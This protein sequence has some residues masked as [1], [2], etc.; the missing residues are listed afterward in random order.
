[1]TT[2]S[3]ARRP[4]PGI[5]HERRWWDAGAVVAGVDEVGRGA[6]AG[7]VTVGAVVLPRHRRL[8]KLRDSKVLTPPERERL[9]VRIHAT[10][11]GVG[12]GHVWND[13]LD[14]WGMSAALRLAARRALRALPLEPDA[15]LLDGNWD[16]LAGCG[17]A[18]E[19]VVGGDGRCASIAAASIVAKVARDALMTEACPGYPAYR[20]SS[21]K[22]YPAPAHVASLARWG[23]SPLHRHSW[24]PIRALTEPRLPL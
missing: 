13:E 19:L 2:A 12:I 6:W 10:A 15:C 14:R 8:Y 23:P 9:A 4:V 20:F 17:T 7:P 24:A 5:R 18:N 21:N 1:M 16:F 3:A 11:L 22:G